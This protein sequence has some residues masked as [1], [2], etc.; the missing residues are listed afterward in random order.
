MFL[1]LKNKPSLNALTL[2]GNKCNKPNSIPANI[3]FLIYVKSIYLLQLCLSINPPK[4]LFS[5]KISCRT[6][7]HCV[8]SPSREI[9][10]W[11]FKPSGFLERCCAPPSFSFSGCFSSARAISATVALIGLC[12]WAGVCAQGN[13]PL[14]CR[15]EI[16][17]RAGPWLLPPS[18]GPGG[19]AGA[20]Q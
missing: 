15:S 13:S 4:V 20:L 10:S 9:V 3:C 11:I 7:I 18:L 6:Q 17:P 16:P 1:H 19:T 2:W 14:C 12:C 5:H 8:H